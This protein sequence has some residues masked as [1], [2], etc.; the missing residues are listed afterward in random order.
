[1][2]ESNETIKSKKREKIRKK[3][4]T[5][6]R[7]FWEILDRSDFLRPT[8]PYVVDWNKVRKFIEIVI[9]REKRKFKKRIIKSIYK[10][11]FKDLSGEPLDNR[12]AKF[13][14]KF[15]FVEN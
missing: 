8:P 3:R 9:R 7:E 2:E 15:P 10:F 11:L 5:W 14:N 1:M 6:E 12:E 13:V 4:K